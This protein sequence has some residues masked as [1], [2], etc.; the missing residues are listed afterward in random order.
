MITL[1]E[2]IDVNRPVA[3]A[4]AYVADF[5]TT[6][7][8]DSTVISARKLSGGPIGAGTLFEVVCRQPLGSVTL[9]YT[10]THHEPGALLRLHGS[11]RFFEVD[12]EIRFT[13][14][15][16]GTRIDYRATFTFQKPL[17]AIAA[18]FQDGLERMGHE[19]VQGLKRALDDN[20]PAPAL[21]DSARWA[22]KLVVPALAQFTRA[23]YNKGKKNWHPVS[24]WMG[25]KHV[26][27]T[28]A[29][30]GLGLAAAHR[31]AELG[32]EL[33]LVIRNESKALELKQAIERESGNNRV[34]IE[35]ADLSLMSEVDRL[36][37]RL[38]RIGKPIDVLVNNAGALFNPRRETAEGLEESFA[39]LLLSP[40]R[41][42][43]GL[44]P[45]LAGAG[46]ARV[47]NVV[48]GGMYSQRLDLERLEAPLENYS[49]SV[50]YARAKR[51]LMIVTEEWA[52]AWA[53]ENI[54]VNAMHPGWARTPGVKSSLP[55]FHRLTRPVLRTPEQGADTI[56]WL[57]TATEAAKT[58]GKLFLDREPRTTHLIASTRETEQERSALLEALA[59]YRPGMTAGAYRALAG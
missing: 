22:D 58:S 9:A 41:L 30:A 24:G 45:L 44:K 47:I 31:L 32:A 51:G 34:R 20:F 4:F 7:Q 50:A 33:T 39:L 5:R 17:A 6:E 12:D 43:E 57:A 26:V 3:E 25:D 37:R 49:G 2:K 1:H 21:P 48:S 40:Y 23:G 54:V 55:T 35:I 10:L 8:W 28:G 11:S 52:K 42:T 14:T 16:T 19:S 36:V 53:G 18:R 59:C 38:K 15:A 13:G 27:I 56:V 46:S 29:S